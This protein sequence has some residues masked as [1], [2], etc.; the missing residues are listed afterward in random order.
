MEDNVGEV[1]AGRKP[2]LPHRQ[3][4]QRTS[5]NFRVATCPPASKRYR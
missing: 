4:P 5:S 2:F 1:V 3:R